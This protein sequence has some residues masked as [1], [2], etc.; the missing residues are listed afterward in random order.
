M[1]YDR[2]ELIDRLAAEYVLGAMSGRVRRR[3]ERVARALPSAQR[4]V[5]DWERRLAPL[6]R[7]VPP[8]EPSSAV[9]QA[10]DRRTRSGRAAATAGW[11]AWL[12]PALGI[13][14]GA[15]LTIGL[16]RLSPETFIPV[17]EIVQAR[18]TLP[19]S[20]VGLLTDK[21]GNPY[22][23]ASSTRHG[24]L[25]T[26]K[27][28]RKIDVPQ[29][30]YLQLW[31]LPKEGA[32]FPLGVVPAEGKGSFVMSDSSEK[33]LSAVPK[34]AVS[35]EDQPARAG[36]KPAPFVLEGNCVKLW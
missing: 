24:K 16:V 29:G 25:M 9:W 18:G 23:L 12:K 35:V 32:A 34:L 11:L 31:A 5:A 14:F 8:V 3:F 6:A 20:Y 22:V 1:N 28:L 36:S 15:V 26:I 30:K 10:I 2:P 33:L 19:Q 4:A 17:D 13:A 7:S 27:I 21:V